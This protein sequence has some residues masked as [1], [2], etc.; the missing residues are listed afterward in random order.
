MIIKTNIKLLNTPDDFSVIF[1][2]FFFLLF[3]LHSFGVEYP[4]T[5]L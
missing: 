1:F 5:D 3:F 2:F 4:H